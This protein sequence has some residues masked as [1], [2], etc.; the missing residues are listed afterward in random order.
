M[1][2]R[3]P[4]CGQ[5]LKDDVKIIDGAVYK[6]VTT[7][8]KRVT[9]KSYSTY[10]KTYEITKWS[11]GKLTCDCPDWTNRHATYEKEYGGPYRCKHIRDNE[12][13]L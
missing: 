12:Y 2:D 5:P 8:V 11:D 3:C 4:T 1:T 13:K 6:R 7:A 9:V 10:G